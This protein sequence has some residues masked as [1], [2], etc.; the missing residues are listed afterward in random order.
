M[1]I[2]GVFAGFALLTTS[3][4][5][6]SPQPGL[7]ADDACLSGEPGQSCGLHALQVG[8]HARGGRSSSALNGSSNASAHGKSST[9]SSEKLQLKKQNH[10]A[11]STKA[12]TNA[13]KAQATTEQNL[14]SKAANV[15]LLR[16]NASLQR[17]PA[18]GAGAAGPHERVTIV[19]ITRG[20]ENYK[21]E[22][23]PGYREEHEQTRWRTNA[24]FVLVSLLPF[25]MV[26]IEV[27]GKRG[28]SETKKMMSLKITQ[29]E[30]SEHNTSSSLWLSIG[31]VVCDVTDFIMLH[32][33]GPDI[34]LQ[35]GGTEAYDAFE[36][37][38]HSEF[39]HKM[40]HEKGIGL[41]VDGD[42]AP[43]TTSGVSVIGRL[44]TKEDSK[45]Y[46]K[47]LGLAIL[48]N[49]AYRMY[50]KMADIFDGG[51]GGDW[52]SLASCWLCMLLQSTSFQFDVPKARLLGSP[53]IWQEWRAHN[54]VFVLRHV[55]GFTVTWAY[56][57]WADPDD[58]TTKYILDAAL[59]A[60]LY[61]QMYAVDVITAWV[62][63]DKHTSLT[64]SWPFWDGCPMWLERFIKYYYTISQFQASSLMILTGFG[65]Y[66]KFLVIFPF[67]FASFLMTL[68]RKGIITTKGFH[69]GYLWSLFI[70][71]WLIIE[72]KPMELVTNYVFWTVLY[73]V[74]SCGLS[75]YAL[76]LGPLMQ[77]VLQEDLMLVPM[78]NMY[79]FGIMAVTW[80]VCMAIQK[81]CMGFAVETRARRFL[82]ARPKPLKLLSREEVNDTM[83]LLKFQVP[84]GYT[85]G[86]NPGQHLKVHVPNPSH[87]R[88]T[89]NDAQN[90]EEPAD[91]VSR[92][93]TPVSPTTSPT[94]DLLVRK[95]P[96]NKERGFPDGGR[97]SSF[98]IDK[99]EI[100]KSIMM[101]GPHG[102]QMY[103][104]QGN[105]L[106][107]KDMVKA[108]LCGAL[109]GGSGITPVLAVLRDIWQ[110]GRRSVTDRDQRILGEQALKLEGFSLLH[111]TRSVGEALSSDWF[112]PPEGA[113]SDLGGLT[114]IT[115]SHVVTGPD[116]PKAE[117][118]GRAN[119]WTGKVT[120]EMVKAALPPPADDVVIFVCGPQGFNET[121][122]R[123]ILKG[124]GYKHV[125]MLQ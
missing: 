86:M 41:L 93:Y 70:V 37:I 38:G 95:Y 28:S 15:V 29:K 21:M 42:E 79:R 9:N 36:E 32:P 6:S 85:A 106:V 97:A 8:L 83:V 121:L 57:R 98:L 122:C 27:R 66:S 10:S 80:I 54:F 74:R 62:R 3:G 72:A 116:A 117:M 49:V 100:G 101:T 55:L 43:R 89:W 78:G 75:K 23:I 63:E 59:F 34:L 7:I 46:H 82:E 4:S 20:V 92:S 113:N 124:L 110:E 47:F 108:R 25:L 115:I 50:A 5:A 73:L 13:S 118:P 39:A 111:A 52:V 30:L 53:M 99:A 31:G 44:F 120:E 105:F 104:G 17:Q 26:M 76:W 18:P 45:N 48:L 107:G 103:Y 125:V 14:S 61:G 65:L 68:V 91:I 87:G 77:A 69:A 94:L 119:C 12:S 11:N 51:F 71:A 90:L 19:D 22:N 16:D 1:W 123:P 40:V 56:L 96:A 81:I 64:A 109:A 35:H 58:R 2:R 33:G 67:Q 24:G 60:V 102:H 114:P 88:K 84:A 112:S